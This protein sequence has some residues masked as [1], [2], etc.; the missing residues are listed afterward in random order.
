MKREWGREE[1]AGDWPSDKA[2]WTIAAFFVA[3]LSVAAICVYRY[4]R[5]WTPLQRHYLLTYTGT[6]TAG[7]LRKDGWY[8][9]LSVVD[10]R[11]Q[12]RLAIGAPGT[13]GTFPRFLSLLEPS[14]PDRL[15][16]FE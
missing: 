3:L 8:T 13:D 16:P 4:E 1:Y 6:P 14:H 9:L 11:G 2:V 10:R 15:N 12:Q 7:A 5:M